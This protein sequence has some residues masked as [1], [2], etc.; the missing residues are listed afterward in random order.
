MNIYSSS[1]NFI[2]FN[3]SYE[4]LGQAMRSNY[5]MYD[6]PAKILRRT[7]EQD[8]ENNFDLAE[9][10]T[11]QIDEMFQESY[12]ESSDIEKNNYSK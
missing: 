11:S 12:N 8:N 6:I 5:D 3:N 2:G 10:K 1:D 4:M 7:K 9:N